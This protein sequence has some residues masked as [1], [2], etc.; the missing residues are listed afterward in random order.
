MNKLPEYLKK[1]LFGEKQIQIQP[2][3]FE[4][5]TI[6]PRWWIA[7][8][9]LKLK[10]YLLVDKYIVEKIPNPNYVAPPHLSYNKE[11]GRFEILPPLVLPQGS[12]G[13]KLDEIIQ[14]EY[15]RLV[16]TQKSPEK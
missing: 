6:H 4:K 10:D 14:K 1:E 5:L 11:K 12:D 2:K 9:L 8:L 3:Y 13:L 16:E 15:E 7:K